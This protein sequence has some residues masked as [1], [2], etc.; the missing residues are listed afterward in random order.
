MFIVFAGG[1]GQKGPDATDQAFEKQLAAAAETNKGTPAKRNS[2][3]TLPDEV[4][5][6]MNAGPPGTAPIK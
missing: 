4:K 5:A 2:M 6:K 1:C 3:A